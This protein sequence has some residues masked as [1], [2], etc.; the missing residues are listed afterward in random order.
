MSNSHRKRRK[1][2]G[3]PLG[4]PLQRRARFCFNEHGGEA[5]TRTLALHLRPGIVLYNGKPTEGQMSS[6]RRALR[7]IGARRVRRDTIDGRAWVWKLEEPDAE[8]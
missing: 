8:G 6:H 4:G 2:R 3:L 1:W 5:S 7:S